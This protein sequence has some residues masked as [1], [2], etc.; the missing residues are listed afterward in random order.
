MPKSRA[1]LQ[2]PLSFLINTLIQSAPLTAT[3]V[4][5]RG[6]AHRQLVGRDGIRATVLNGAAKRS[7]GADRMSESLNSTLPIYFT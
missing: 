1:T 7:P 6:C 2:R 3:V 5:G 4:S